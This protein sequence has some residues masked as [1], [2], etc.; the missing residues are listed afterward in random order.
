MF[1]TQHYYVISRLLRGHFT[2]VNYSKLIRDFTKMFSDDN[3]K[4]DKDK[5]K[6]ACKPKL[7]G[8]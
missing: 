3:K 6:E 8:N 2:Y 4:F 7:G 1:T 5:F